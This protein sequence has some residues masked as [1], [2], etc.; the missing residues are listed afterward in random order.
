MLGDKK[1]NTNSTGQNPFAADFFHPLC[2]PIVL[3]NAAARKL[4]N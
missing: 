4:I 1:K 3:I 2:L